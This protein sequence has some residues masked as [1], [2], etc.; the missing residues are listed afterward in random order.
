MMALIQWS[1]SYSVNIKE[2]D[3]Q[4][5]RLVAIIN[6]LHDAMKAGRGNEVLGTIFSKLAQYVGNH[7]ATE[8][9]L[10]SSY[11][12]PGYLAHKNE[13]AKLTQKVLELQKEF[14]KGVPVLTVELFSFLKDWIH[15]HILGADKKFGPFLNSKGVK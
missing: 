7:F 13:H 2:V 3:D 1:D 14:Q 10:M 4:H 9:R 15:G 6:E 12:Y 11:N 5:K 8:E